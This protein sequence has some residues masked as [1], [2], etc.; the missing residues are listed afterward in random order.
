MNF[1]SQVRKTP[2]DTSYTGREAGVWERGDV[3]NRVTEA[4]VDGS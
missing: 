3:A 2:V 4:S 1:E